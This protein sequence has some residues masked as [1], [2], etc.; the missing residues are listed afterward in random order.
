VDKSK[1]SSKPRQFKDL[2][3]LPCAWHLNSSHTAGDC[4]NFKNYTQKNDL[5]KGKGKLDNDNKD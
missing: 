2:E 4:R 5:A 1:K 3:N